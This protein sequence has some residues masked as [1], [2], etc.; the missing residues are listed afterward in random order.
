MTLTFLF[1]CLA[2]LLCIG[3]IITYTHLAIVEKKQF[4]RLNGKGT[5]PRD[6]YDK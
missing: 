5:F 6:D 4:E 2:F 3:A 1:L